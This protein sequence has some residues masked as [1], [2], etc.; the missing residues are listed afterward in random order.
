MHIKGELS[1]GEDF[2]FDGTFEGSIDLPNHRF[3]A[4]K[5]AQVSA[6]ITAKEVTVDGRVDGYIAADVVDVGPNAIVTA[7]IVAPKFVVE[8]GAVVN[9]SV[10]TERARAAGNIARHKQ[11]PA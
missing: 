1:A 4:G 9:G 3:E 5:Q 2:T 8:E 6:S 11:R 10:N 7:N